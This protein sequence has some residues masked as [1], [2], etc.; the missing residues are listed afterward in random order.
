[1]AS[2]TRGFGARASLPGM[3]AGLPIYK[4]MVWAL[5]SFAQARMYSW[6]FL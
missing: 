1:M 6:L 4:V 5:P 2:V 3:E